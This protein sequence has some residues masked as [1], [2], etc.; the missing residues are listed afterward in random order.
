MTV[1][2]DLELTHINNKLVNQ[3]N[4]LAKL[5][6]HSKTGHFEIKFSPH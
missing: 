4:E 3:A 2:L 5:L 1:R 6:N